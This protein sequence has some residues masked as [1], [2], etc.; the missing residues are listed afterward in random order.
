MK[1]FKKKLDGGS[2]LHQQAVSKKKN[3]LQINFCIT[4]LRR[5]RIIRPAQHLKIWVKHL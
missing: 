3:T 2:L 4:R 1:I 5:F